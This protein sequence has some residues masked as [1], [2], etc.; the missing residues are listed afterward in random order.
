M[1]IF[2]FHVRDGTKFLADPEGSEFSTAEAAIEEATDAVRDLVAERVRGR[3][4]LTQAA[5]EVTDADGEVIKNLPF[6]SVLMLD[7]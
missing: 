1:E 4:P 7:Q 3:L 6:I 5:M 2:C